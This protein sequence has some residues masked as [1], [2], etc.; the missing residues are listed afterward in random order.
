MKTQLP[1]ATLIF[2]LTLSLTSCGVK[3]SPVA[4]ADNPPIGIGKPTPP[5]K[6]DEKKTSQKR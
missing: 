2:L 1:Q 5:S 4:P 3:G 6:K